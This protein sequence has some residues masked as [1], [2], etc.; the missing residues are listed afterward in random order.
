MTELEIMLRA[1]QYID[2]LANGINPLTGQNVK[3]DDVVN[4]V[5]ISRCLFYV[6]DV[7][8][9]VID[10]DGK[11]CEPKKRNTQRTEFN[12]TDEQKMNLKPES[13]SKSSSRIVS[14][15]NEQID[16]ENMK[17]LKATTLNNWLVSIGML[18]EIP[19]SN[20]KFRKIPTSEGE[21][22][23]LSETEF[24]DSSGSHKYVIYNTSAQQFIFD[25]I[26]SI[27]EFAHNEELEKNKE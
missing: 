2:N 22:L 23:G 3:E 10:N 13:T 24:S 20:G 4:N 12:L 27:I 18:E 17:K 21:M 9:K 6:S 16:A 5:R 7:L 19:V 11:I 8:R 14:A 26:D 1:K 25:N 15:I